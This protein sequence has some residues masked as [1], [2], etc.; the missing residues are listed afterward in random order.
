MEGL[1]L[2]IPNVDDAWVYAEPHPLT[3][4]TV[5]AQVASDE[6]SD[7]RKLIRNLRQLITEKSI[8][9]EHVPTRIEL[10]DQIQRYP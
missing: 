6:I 3:G 5:V 10:V 9:L 2:S 4:Q 8:S 7:S 1:I